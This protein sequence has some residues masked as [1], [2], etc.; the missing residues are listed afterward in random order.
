MVVASLEIDGFRNFSQ[1]SLQFSTG[2]NLITGVN[3]S[4][5]TS[6]LE[7]LYF[8]GRARSFRTQRV[9]ELIHHGLTAFRLI[10]MLDEADGRRIPVGVQRD[11]SE[12][13]AR[14]A[15]AP[16]QSL[17]QLARQMPV[18]LLNPNSHRL[19]ED[20]PQQ[21]RRFM[22]WGLFHTDAAFWAVWK[23]Y[24]LA[25]RN[26]NAALRTQVNDRVL[27]AWD[28]ELG[29]AAET[30]DR[31]RNTF[32][33]ALE[34]V[35]QPLVGETLGRVAISL[36]Y[37]P[38][39]AR[40]RHEKLPPILREMRE[41]DRRQGYTHAGPHRADLLIK[42]GG[43]PVLECLSRGQ[44]KLLVIAL[45]LTQAR[46]YR[47]QRDS[48]CMLLIDDLPAELDRLHRRQVMAW[49][50]ESVCQ[51]FVTALEAEALDCAAWADAKTLRIDQGKLI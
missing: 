49:L 6:L 41:Q 43:R 19:L 20:G 40:T 38:G 25:L 12:L 29:Q 16:V 18:L 51:L 28:E 39:W 14:I 17:A 1:L 47:N 30:L 3:A 31:L 26:R 35:L 21:R 36:E 34:G 48:A 2:L 32:C 5:K 50:A 45:V 24:A 8:L 13:L 37:R 9:Q 7:A 23:R 22:D 11:A 46:L 27:N 10:A 33:T 15:G 44:Q 42:L 4:G